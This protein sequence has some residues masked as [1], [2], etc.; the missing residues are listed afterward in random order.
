M[1]RESCGSA[2]GSLL[3]DE[4]YRTGI[5]LEGK[6]PLFWAVPAGGTEGDYQRFAAGLKEPASGLA[7]RYIDLGNV[8]TISV[9]EY[10]GAALWQILKG[11]GSPF[12]STL[13]MALIDKYSAEGQGAPLLGEL[14]RKEIQSSGGGLVDPYLFLVDRLRQFYGGLNLPSVT[15]LL[16]MCF[17]MRNL[18]SQRIARSPDET[19]LGQTLATGRR[20]GWKKQEM[21]RLS[22]PQAWEAGLHEAFR[23]QILEFLIDAYQ[24]IRDRTRDVPVKISDR[25]MTIVG[26]KLKSFF[27]HRPG[28]LPFEFS[29][30]NAAQTSQIQFEEQRAAGKTQWQVRLLIGSPEKPLFQIVRLMPN[31]LV[32]CAWCSMNGFWDGRQ[33]LR[34]SCQASLTDTGLKNMMQ[35]LATFFPMDESENQPIEDLLRDTEITHLYILPNWDDP[36][37]QQYVKSIIVFY[38][39][40]LGEIFYETSSERQCVEWLVKELIGKRIGLA[41][42]IRLQWKVFIATGRISSTRRLSDELSRTI[43]KA[44]SQRLKPPRILR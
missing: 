30:F 16:E 23:R 18:I 44:I 5:L 9:S 33:E 19:R 3:K 4:F 11:L 26:K 36:D 43:A 13:K 42:L 35:S 34:L 29:F 21:E 15:R 40:S 28:K 22:D 6:L 20:W 7:G 32:A 39:N 17:L 25:D 12:K 37:W 8:R 41:R 31:A 10:F 27:E 1:T 38:R 2:L 24:R 14:Y